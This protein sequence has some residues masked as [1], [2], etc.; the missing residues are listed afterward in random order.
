MICHII[1]LLFIA[2]TLQCIISGK[3]SGYCAYN[4]LSP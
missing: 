1:P 4:P 3:E 2:K